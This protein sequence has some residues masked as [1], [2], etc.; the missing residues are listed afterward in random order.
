MKTLKFDYY[1][2]RLRHLLQPGDHERRMAWARFILEQPSE[3]FENL[4]VVDEASFQLGAVII[5][6]IPTPDTTTLLH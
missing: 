6:L 4:L 2:P 5:I 3:F 1:I